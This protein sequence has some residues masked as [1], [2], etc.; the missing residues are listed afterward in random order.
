M[1]RTKQTARKSVG[2]KQLQLAHKSARK[3]VKS[4]GKKMLSSSEGVMIKNHI[5]TNQVQ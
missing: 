3:G 2:S 4:I 5:D 1:A